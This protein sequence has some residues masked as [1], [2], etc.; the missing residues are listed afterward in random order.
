MK[1]I[2]SILTLVASTQTLSAAPLVQDPVFNNA[3]VSVEM[4]W[5]ILALLALLAGLT[6]FFI[7]GDQK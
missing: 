6:F 2:L 5:V 4:A 1:T 7:K 3:P